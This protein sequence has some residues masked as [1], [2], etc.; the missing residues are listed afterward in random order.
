MKSPLTASL[1]GVVLFLAT[2]GYV[3][4][5]PY[6][7][8]TFGTLWG[9]PLAW[10]IT[11]LPGLLWQVGLILTL[12]LVGVPLCG[13]A[14]EF[15]GKKDPGAVVWDEI[16]TVPIV[17][18]GWQHAELSNPWLLLAGFVLHRIFDI[19]KL[20]PANQLERLPGG[21]GI[22]ADDVAAACYAGLVLSLGHRFV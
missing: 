19:S 2:G 12:L 21:W 3:G 9:L 4:F 14:A 13:R 22:M 16:V 10:A 6:A 20:P 8:G 7:P 11:L 15:L 5:S 18:L 17:F 1:R